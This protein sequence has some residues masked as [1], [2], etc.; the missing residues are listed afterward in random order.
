MLYSFLVV[1]MATVY[2][3]CLVFCNPVSCDHIDHTVCLK[4]LQQSFIWKRTKKGIPMF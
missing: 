1:L 2:V 3:L 4:Q